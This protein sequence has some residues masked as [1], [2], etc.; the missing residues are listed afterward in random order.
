MVTRLREGFEQVQFI[1]HS[2]GPYGASWPSL[3]DA[4][5][6]LGRSIALFVSP[7]LT[8]GMAGCEQEAGASVRPS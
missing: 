7:Q 8:E 4:E 1:R 2:I 6:V 5:A 3:P